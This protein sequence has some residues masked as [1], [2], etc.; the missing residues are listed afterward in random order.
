MKLIKN[1]RA[2]AKNYAHPKNHLLPERRRIGKEGI[3]AAC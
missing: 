1:D 2:I 3:S